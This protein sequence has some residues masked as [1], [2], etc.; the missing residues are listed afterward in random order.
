MSKAQHRW[1]VEEKKRR[2]D[3][4]GSCKFCGCYRKKTIFGYEYTTVDG[5]V[6]VDPPECTG[7]QNK[8]IANPIM[9]SV[10]Q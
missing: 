1:V 7:Y 5:K 4:N 2:N 10:S 9:G 6:Y 8:P 3:G